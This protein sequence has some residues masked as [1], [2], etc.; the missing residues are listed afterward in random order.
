MR[1][2]T[3]LKTNNPCL[4]LHTGKMQYSIDKLKRE[5]KVTP[6]TLFN[7][8]S[9]LCIVRIFKVKG[10]WILMQLKIMTFKLVFKAG[11]KKKVIIKES[12]L[13]WVIGSTVTSLNLKMKF[14]MIFYKWI[15]SHE[16]IN[17]RFTWLKIGRINLVSDAKLKLQF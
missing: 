14:F 4:T 12:I 5:D 17:K 9:K 11:W 15:N 3:T 2:N 13:F 7:Q 1:F 16:Q 8:Y 10:I 6:L